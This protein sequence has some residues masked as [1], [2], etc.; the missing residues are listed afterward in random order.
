M[1]YTTTDFGDKTTV[2]LID[3]SGTEYEVDLVNK[4]GPFN[5]TTRSLNPEDAII[6]KDGKLI[7]P[8]GNSYMQ[9]DFHKGNGIYYGFMISL[10]IA[11]EVFNSKIYN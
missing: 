11:I 7:I 10:L 1:F 4:V 5:I 9:T 8:I 6:E 3:T 2:N